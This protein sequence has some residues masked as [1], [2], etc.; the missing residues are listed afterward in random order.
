LYPTIQDFEFVIDDMPSFPSLTAIFGLVALVTSL[1]TRRGFSQ[2]PPEPCTGAGLFGSAW[3]GVYQTSLTNNY[4][5]WSGVTPRQVA[6]NST[7][8]AKP[9]SYVSIT[10]GGFL[11]WWN[12]AGTNYFYMFF[13]SG[14]G[15]NAGN[16]L[17]AP[18]DEYKIMI[19]RAT[20]ASGPFF[21][22]SGKNCA[23]QNG[24][25]LVLGSHGNVYAPGG[26]GVTVD[27]GRVVLYLALW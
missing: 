7:Y 3:N 18:G 4:L 26:Q 2:P 15:C 10:E 19:C 25:T 6:Y 17:Q 13:S 16:D 21:D 24:G 1:N 23:K 5:K 8:P 14:A 9:Q 20:S 11:F 22:K 27:G 12:V